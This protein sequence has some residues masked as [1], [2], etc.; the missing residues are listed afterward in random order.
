VPAGRLAA[1][2]LRARFA[3]P[4]AFSP[5]QVADGRLFAPQRASRS[6]AVLIALAPAMPVQS[7]D[8]GEAPRAPFPEAP[9]E[10]LFTLRSARLR[11]HG[12]QISFPGGRAEPGD[13]GPHETALRE[14]R[15]EIGL[16]AREVEIL[17]SLPQ[18]LTIS[19]YRVT[20]VVGLLRTR[21]PL[22]PDPQEVEEV[23][24]VP[25]AHLMD[26]A[27]HQ[28]RLVATESPARG[29]YAMTYA[30]SRRHYIWGATAAMLRNLYRFLQA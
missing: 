27:N 19:G 23:F 1:G 20:P 24:G 25:L 2:A 4:P 8:P 10:I 30:G 11:D 14:A 18:Y 26:P 15:E 5:D 29:I 22:H 6:A 17:G 16:E 13:A 21:P 12:G 7:A 28:R 3:A 9:L